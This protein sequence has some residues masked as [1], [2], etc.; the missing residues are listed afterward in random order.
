MSDT[1]GTRNGS[2][3][4][5][6]VGRLLLEAGFD[7]DGALRPALL[8]LRALAGEQPVPSAAVAALM[9]PAVTRTAAADA[10]G[11]TGEPAA[12]TDELA[13]RR[14]AKRRFTLT[15]LSVAV[16]LA[17]GGAVAVASDQGIR[18]SIGQ[19]NHAVTSFVSTVGGGPAP[20]PAETP[21][22]VQPGVPAVGPTGPAVTAP[23]PAAPGSVSGQATQQTPAP[24]GSAPSVPLPDPSLPETVVPGVPGVP[25]GPL[26]GEGQPPAL[27]LPPSPPVPL[28]RVHP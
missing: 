17:A 7:D 22:P 23:V 13:A 24:S 3:D 5:A 12:A 2:R 10:P 11:A 19:V 14:R 6:S 27:P 26:N 20:A 28:P 25:G 4:D 21:G 1:A 16:S 8:E 18:D 15:T 9:M